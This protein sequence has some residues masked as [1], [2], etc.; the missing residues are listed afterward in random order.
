MK[1]IAL[2]FF[3]ITISISAYSQAWD[4]KG[5]VKISAGFEFYSNYNAHGNGITA[6]IDYGVLEDISIG[7]GIDYNLDSSNIYFNGRT[8]FHFQRVFR[9][10][11]FFDV[12]TGLDF[13]YNTQYNNDFGI[14][15]HVGTRVMVTDA[16]GLYVELGTRGVGGFVYNF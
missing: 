6:S 3:I 5:D 14:G 1:K 9:L 2:T 12:Y 13:G 16:L 4:G 11:S 8:D 15:A 10:P 7:A